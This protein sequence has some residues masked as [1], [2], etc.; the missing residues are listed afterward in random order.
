M[1]P[2]SPIEVKKLI[3]KRVLRGL[4]RGKIPSKYS[5][6]KLS[7]E[8]MHSIVDQKNTNTLSSL[9]KTKTVCVP[10]L[11][12]AKGE[13]DFALKERAGNLQS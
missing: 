3:E 13:L 6:R 12:G 1:T 10:N 5:A 9:P 8:E 7:K 11:V 4:S 2:P